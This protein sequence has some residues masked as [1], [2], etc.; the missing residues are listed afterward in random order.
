MCG[1]EDRAVQRKP[2]K[3]LAAKY[4]VQRTDDAQLSATVKSLEP[5]HLGP[6]FVAEMSQEG[7]KRPRPI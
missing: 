4:F 1:E 3:M 7:Q 5:C 2:G 6:S